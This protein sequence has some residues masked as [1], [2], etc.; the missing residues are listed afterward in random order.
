MVNSPDHGFHAC[1]LVL[2]TLMLTFIL[3][4]KKVVLNN[5]EV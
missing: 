2:N 3:T 1:S 4:V 5:L